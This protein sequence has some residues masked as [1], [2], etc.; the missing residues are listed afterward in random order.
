MR[1]QNLQIVPQPPNERVLAPVIIL[2]F[3]VSVRLFLKFQ[4]LVT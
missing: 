2:Q 3:E 4:Q 1:E